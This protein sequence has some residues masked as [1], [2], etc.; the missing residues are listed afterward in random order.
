MVKLNEECS[1]MKEDV[2]SF[3]DTRQEVKSK[4]RKVLL[5]NGSIEWIY[6]N[7]KVKP[8]VEEPFDGKKISVDKW[9]QPNRMKRWRNKVD[10]NVEL[11]KEHTKAWNESHMKKKKFK[12]GDI[13]KTR[14]LLRWIDKD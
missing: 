12:N 4:L 7:Q 5:L 11:Y 14:V 2:P 1:D 6:S 10:E 3:V 13:I 9:R 8:P